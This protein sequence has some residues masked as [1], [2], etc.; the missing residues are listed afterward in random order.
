ME[1]SKEMGTFAKILVLSV[2][3]MLFAGVLHF[4]HVYPPE[5]IVGPEL[6]PDSRL[7]AALPAAIS[8]APTPV[9]KVNFLPSDILYQ[10]EAFRVEFENFSEAPSTLYFR[11]KEHPIFS[12]GGKPTAVV[13]LDIDEETG[14]AEVRIGEEKF[15]V[16]I[17]SGIFQVEEIAPPKPLT[18]RELARR[19]EERETIVSVYGT[20][21]PEAYFDSPFI[22][23]LDALFETSPFGIK[24]LVKG[25]GQKLSSHNG[26]DFRAAVGTPVKAV[27]DGI[28]ELAES[29]LFEGG[30]VIIDHGFG[31]NSVYLHLSRV[32][33]RNGERVTKGQAVGLSGGSGQS[34]GPHLHFTIK[35][36]GIAVDP[37]RFLALW[38]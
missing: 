31:I 2:V 10:G 26:T 13:P 29:Y 9:P 28:V 24:R 18:P 12:Y 33:V 35:I 16:S 20:V 5:I 19:A 23:P 4:S 38:K 21:A 34:V 11:G 22:P 30:F 3:V 15:L 6:E 25:T 37:L 14:V 27:N 36:N 1:Q 32:D 7:Q 17:V 8:P